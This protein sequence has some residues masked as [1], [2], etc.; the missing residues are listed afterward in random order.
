ME[1]ESSKEKGIPIPFV[2][3][4]NKSIKID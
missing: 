2:V 3:Y 1:E 4:S